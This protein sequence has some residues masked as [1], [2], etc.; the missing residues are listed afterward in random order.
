MISSDSS[1]IFIHVLADNSVQLVEVTTKLAVKSVFE[2]FLDHSTSPSIAL[3]IVYM[4]MRDKLVALVDLNG[5]LSLVS[6]TTS[7][8]LRLVFELPPQCGHQNKIFYPTCL[9]RSSKE[10]YILLGGSDS[11][12]PRM[13]TAVITIYR[14]EDSLVSMDSISLQE[15]VQ[16]SMI[17]SCISK[18]PERDVFVVG[19]YSSVFVVE[20]NGLQLSSIAAFQG[21]HSCRVC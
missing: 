7:K 5:R 14:L 12:D 20:W 13:G 16:R 21:L 8:G 6:K 18:M 19:T 4:P 9:T 15:G 10:G 17:A 11:K 1:S 3:S 2:S